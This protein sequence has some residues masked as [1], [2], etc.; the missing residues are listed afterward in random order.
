MGGPEPSTKQ[1]KGKEYIKQIMT[2]MSTF[3]NTRD[4]L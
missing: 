3:N 1:V 4:N 2:E